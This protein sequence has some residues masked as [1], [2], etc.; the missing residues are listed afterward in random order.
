[1]CVTVRGG[2]LCSAPVFI[3]VGLLGTV[4]IQV[5]GGEPESAR[6][7]VWTGCDFSPS[8]IRPGGFAYLYLLA[9][10]RLATKRQHTTQQQ[11]DRNNRTTEQQEDRREGHTYLHTI[12]TLIPTHAGGTYLHTCLLHIAEEGGTYMTRIQE[13]DQGRTYLHTCPRI[14]APRLYGRDCWWAGVGLG[15]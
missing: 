8:C 9:N 5:W 15:I 2:V 12:P 7:T 10:S 11:E 6:G 3:P 4:D 13:D 14:Y 1:M